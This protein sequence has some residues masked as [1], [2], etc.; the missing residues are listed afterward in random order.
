MPRGFNFDTLI[1][2]CFYRFIY[3]LDVSF[4]VKWF[5]IRRI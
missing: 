5:A 2:Y 3:M 1:L 4:I